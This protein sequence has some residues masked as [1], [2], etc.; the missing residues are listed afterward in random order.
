[1]QCLGPRIQNINSHLMLNYSL[2]VDT[3]F[4]G[5]NKDYASFGPL[6]GVG[7]LHQTNQRT[8]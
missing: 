7:K 1:M 5:T 8:R 4:S 6:Q 3:L 2:I